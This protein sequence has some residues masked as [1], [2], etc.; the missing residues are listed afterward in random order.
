MSGKDSYEG[1]LEP[2][3][4]SDFCIY[5]VSEM[6]VLYQGVVRNL[7]KIVPVATVIINYI[8]RM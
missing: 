7:K 8:S 1:F 2:S 5:L 4:I 6:Y 3:A